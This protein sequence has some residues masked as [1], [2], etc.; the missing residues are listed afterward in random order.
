M[1]PSST[2]LNYLRPQRLRESKVCPIVQYCI[3]NEPITKNELKNN[4]I[5]NVTVCSYD[6][7][8]GKTR[9]NAPNQSSK[10]EYASFAKRFGRTRVS[11]G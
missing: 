7:A 11:H 6:P 8:P 5:T 9:Q 3:H 10:M 2:F 1:F 4:T